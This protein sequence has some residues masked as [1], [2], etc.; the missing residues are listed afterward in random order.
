MLSKVSEQIHKVIVPD[1]DTIMDL[2]IYFSKQ[3]F[4]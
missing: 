1:H 4:L 3:Y 2:Q